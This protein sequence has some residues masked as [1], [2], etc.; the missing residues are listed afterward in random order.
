MG[1]PEEVV[2]EPEP[3]ETPWQTHVGVREELA[4][5]AKQ[6]GLDVSPSSS[7]LQQNSHLELR[8]EGLK[9]FARVLIQKS[10]M[11]IRDP[12]AQAHAFASL[13]HSGHTIATIFHRQPGEPIVACLLAEDFFWL[14]SQ[15]ERATAAPE[16]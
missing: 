15:A 8:S 11:Q 1:E 6:E 7:R 16:E 3:T 4:A 10:R 2:P 5:M 14:L 12:L 13:D 9:L